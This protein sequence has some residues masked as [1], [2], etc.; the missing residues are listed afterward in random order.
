MLSVEGNHIYYEPSIEEIKRLFDH[1]VRLDINQPVCIGTWSD[2]SS[3]VRPKTSGK[4]MTSTSQAKPSNVGP[5][6]LIVLEGGSLG[7]VDEACKLICR[8]D[9]SCIPENAPWEM[10]VAHRL[11][12]ANHPSDE[13]SKHT[14]DASPMTQDIVSEVSSNHL[15]TASESIEYV[16][17]SFVHQSTINDYDSS[18][19]ESSMSRSQSRSIHGQLRVSIKS[20]E[21]SRKRE[22]RVD[23]VPTKPPLTYA[24]THLGVMGES[25]VTDRLMKLFPKMVVERV[26]ATPHVGDIH[27]TDIKRSMMFMVEVKN[28]TILTKENIDKF[29]SDLSNVDEKTDLRVIGVF[30]SLKS[31]IPR[32]GTCVIQ[33]DRCYLA[34][35]YTSDEALTMIVDVYR[36]LFKPIETT[37]EKVEY[38]VPDNVKEL[39]FRLKNEHQSLA[40]M[41]TLIE[42]QLQFNTTSS[43]NMRSMLMKIELQR[44]LIMFIDQA[45]GD[46]INDD[47]RHDVVANDE[48]QLR[49]YINSTPVKQIRKAYITEHFNTVP[50]LNRMKL[51]DIIEKYRR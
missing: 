9:D 20:S 34:Q 35:S 16:N 1:D 28:K 11:W 19:Y 33:H 32:F 44:Q 37:V 49:D 24:S 8:S 42:Q 51:A 27:L 40:S 23:Q 47:V 46:V 22:P 21:S 25:D 6:G 2:I 13:S 7:W 50:G 36:S 43:D 31:T 14:R 39:L 12:K 48:D 18:D 17:S 26:S 29:E 5:N 41:K 38:I 15:D 4:K 30:L 45:F 3:T 10:I